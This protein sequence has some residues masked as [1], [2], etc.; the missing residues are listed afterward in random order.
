MI[1][2]KLETASDSEKTETHFGISLIMAH[3]CTWSVLKK[4][5]KSLMSWF[6]D[7]IE[8]KSYIKFSLPDNVT[9]TKPV[10]K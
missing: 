4:R 1:F 8:I 6:L 10:T 7:F 3:P 2:T 5:V 9:S